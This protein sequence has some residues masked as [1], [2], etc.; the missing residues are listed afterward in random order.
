M[1]GISIKQN[2]NSFVGHARENLLFDQAGKLDRDTIGYLKFRLG[3]GVAPVAKSILQ[4]NSLTD[5]EKKLLRGLAVEYIF[6]SPVAHQFVSSEFDRGIKMST[7]RDRKT[8]LKGRMLVNNHL[9]IIMDENIS[10]VKSSIKFLAY[11]NSIR[12][13][14]EDEHDRQLLL[15]RPFSSFH[16]E[17]S[18]RM[19]S[20][21]FKS[22]LTGGSIH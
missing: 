9:M 21:N 13:K 11:M 5:P 7:S 6:D 2:D 20:L 1:F 15:T 10:N 14:I 12:S 16:P 4:K 8:R 22:R 17:Q 19:D 3:K 18:S